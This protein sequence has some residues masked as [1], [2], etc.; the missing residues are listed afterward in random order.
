[1]YNRRKRRP[2]LLLLIVIAVIGGVIFYIQDNQ[3]SSAPDEAM[4]EA[5]ALPP[6]A[7]PT[8]VAIMPTATAT[9]QPTASAFLPQIPEDAEI[10][11]PTAGVRTRIVQAFLDGVSWDVSQ[12]G[13]NA[14]HLQGT[15]WLTEGGNVVLSG[16]VERSDGQPGIFA[17]LDELNVGDLVVVTANGNE[18]RYSIVNIHNTTPDD[19]TP[20]YPAESDRLTLITCG[21]YN[22]LQDSYLERTVV[23]A[24]RVS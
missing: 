11:I 18:W 1:M 24:E 7:Q 13:D 8:E 6:T 23:V 21:N 5:T 12:L 20:L 3:P 19:L 15:S 4:S 9:A 14:G 16:H 22:F 10:F 17:R 2:P